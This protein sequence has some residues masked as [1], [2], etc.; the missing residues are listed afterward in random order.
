MVLLN[1]SENDYHTDNATKA[2]EEIAKGKHDNSTFVGKTINFTILDSGAS[3]MVW[4][5][6]WFDC[7]LETLSEKE[8]KIP[9][10]VSAKTFKFRDGVKSKSLKVVILPCV[11]TKMA[12]KIISYVVDADIPQEGNKKSTDIPQL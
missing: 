8:K 5:K 1:E 3:T 10:R 7:F 11:V 6:K 12:I 9:T 2:Y 4:G